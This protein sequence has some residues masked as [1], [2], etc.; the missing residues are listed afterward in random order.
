MAGYIYSVKEVDNAQLD[1]PG[2]TRIQTTRKYE[3]R[4]FLEGQL[5]AGLS[6]AQFEVTRSRDGHA[7]TAHTYDTYQ[8]M[9][10]DL[11]EVL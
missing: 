6:L 3:A 5:E 7:D 10:I 11:G 9:D 2:Q 8:F 1:Y 4:K